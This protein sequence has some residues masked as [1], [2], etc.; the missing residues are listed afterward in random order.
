M[1]QTFWFLWN[2]TTSFNRSALLSNK[3]AA[4]AKRVLLSKSFGSYVCRSLKKAVMPSR[5]L[6][7]LPESPWNDPLLRSGAHRIQPANCGLISHIFS[8]EQV[9]MLKSLWGKCLLVPTDKPNLLSPSNT[10]FWN[11][12]NRKNRAGARMGALCR[13]SLTLPPGQ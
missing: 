9:C 8:V 1:I 13:G 11:V 4:T 5:T 2:A 3:S 12:P 10:D 7:G 6:L